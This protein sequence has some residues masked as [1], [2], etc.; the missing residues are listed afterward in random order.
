LSHRPH[1]RWSLRC[2]LSYYLN[3]QQSRRPN[4]R[5]NHRQSQSRLSR[6]QRQNLPNYRRYC[7]S[8]YPNCRS[9]RHPSYRRSQSLNHHWNC[10]PIRR[11]NHRQS[12]HPSH[13]R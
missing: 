13:C 11:P 4:C 1:H 5:L 3:Y 12:R 7:Q 2:H 10:Y 6:N 8:C 9:I